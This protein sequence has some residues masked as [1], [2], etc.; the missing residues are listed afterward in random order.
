MRI[1]EVIGTVVLSRSHPSLRGAQWKLVAPL[2][3]DNLLERSEVAAEY[4]VAYDEL[5]AG[6]G[7]RV[8]IS[9]GRE[10]AFPFFP[11]VKPI[12]TYL[13]AILDRLEV[14]R[15]LIADILAES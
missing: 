13:A 11:E 9:E 7:Q 6:A 4:A 3:W 15:P 2:S 14:D 8:A 12:D 1:A 5:G 10:A